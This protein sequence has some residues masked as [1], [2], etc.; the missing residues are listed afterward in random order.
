[1]ALN[2]SKCD[3]LTPTSTSVMI[4]DWLTFTVLNWI[5]GVSEFRT[6]W[7]ISCCLFMLHW[8]VSSALLCFISLY[9]RMLW[10]FMSWIS[11]F[12]IKLGSGHYVLGPT[13]DPAGSG[14]GSGSGAP[15]IVI[16]ISRTYHYCSSCHQTSTIRWLYTVSQKKF[17]PLNSL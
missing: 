2:T 15:L 16:M 5:D 12:N 14:S 9:E 3:H 8:V 6:I 7:R 10:Y 4:T 1:M 11:T 17:L 13:S